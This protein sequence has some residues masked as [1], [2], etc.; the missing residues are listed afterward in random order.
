MLID[1]REGVGLKKNNNSKSFI[2]YW[3]DME[4]IYRN[5]EEY[6]PVK[7]RKLLFVFEDV[8]AGIIS[9]K[10]NKPVETELH[11]T[12]RKLIISHKK[13]NS[14]IIKSYI[15]YKDFIMTKKCTTKPYSFSVID[16]IL[17]SDN[18]LCFRKKL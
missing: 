11:I 9:N 18:S 2:E 10:K 16:I 12:G 15:D 14:F 8:I 1:K 17:E 5:I 4:D 6:N 7:E 13:L 3:N